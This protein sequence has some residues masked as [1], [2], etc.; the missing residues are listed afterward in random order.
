M[1]PSATPSIEVTNPAIEH[2][3]KQAGSVFPFV[4]CCESSDASTDDATRWVASMRKELLR[5]ASSHGAVLLR[6]FP[7]R[8][9]E[10]FDLLISAL[11]IPNFP[12]KK[13]LSN[14]VRINRT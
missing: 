13:S 7:V 11:S 6:G 1:S 12:Y 8:S 2:E 4:F 10:D 3:Q 9:A 14:A 5:H